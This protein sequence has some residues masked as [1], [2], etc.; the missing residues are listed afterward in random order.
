[1]VVTSA[2]VE[3]EFA[4]FVEEVEQRLLRGLVGA[5][6]PEVGREAT[7]DALAYAW[8]HWDQVSAMD[9]PVGYLYRVG[10][11]RSRAYRR[12][13]VWFPEVAENELPNVDPRLPSALRRLSPK[14]RAAVVLRFVEELTER[15]AADAL[16]ISRAT[17]RKHAQRGL[18]KLRQELG[19]RDGQ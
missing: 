6:G 11:T 15:E 1:M 10:Q 3:R 16:E 9:N 4:C 14:Q 13:R 17:L 18:A 8:E 12:D 2:E 5:Y 19:V 7:R